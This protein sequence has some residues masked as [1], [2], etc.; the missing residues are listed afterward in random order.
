MRYEGPVLAADQRKDQGLHVGHHLLRCPRGKLSRM[1]LPIQP[2]H[3]VGQNGADDGAA[4]RLPES[5]AGDRHRKIGKPRN[6][7]T[8]RKGTAVWPTEYPEHTEP[9]PS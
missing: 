4:F 6:T 3:L 5:R 8:T 9:K 2:P 1:G 7:R